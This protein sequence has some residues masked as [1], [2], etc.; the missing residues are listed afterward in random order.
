VYTIV[1]VQLCDYASHLLFTYL[2]GTVVARALVF[3]STYLMDMR[4]RC[5][6]LDLSTRHRQWKKLR[7][8]HQR[9]LWRQKRFSCSLMSRF[10]FIVKGT[11]CIGFIQPEQSDDTDITD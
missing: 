4:R 7:R 8:C 1:F 11:L 5:R 3:C 2:V 10:T 9:N 6:P